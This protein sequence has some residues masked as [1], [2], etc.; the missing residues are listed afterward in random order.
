MTATTTSSPQQVTTTIGRLARA[1]RAAIPFAGRDATLPAIELVHLHCGGGTL[2][3][4]ATN[5]YILGHARIP[6]TGALGHPR[7]LH[8]SDAR[9]LRKDL[10]RRIAHRQD[11]AELVTLTEN[12]DHLTV[13]YGDTTITYTTP[14]GAG[15]APHLARILTALVTNDTV[16]VLQPIGLN[17]HVIKPVLKVA[18]LER[19]KPMRWLMTEPGQ[20]S[21]VEI[22]DWFVAAVMPAK[23]RG[24][25]GTISVDLPGSEAPSAEASR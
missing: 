9:A 2:T 17:A 8:R 20:P 13:G 19:Q 21:R 18:R 11:S 4:T 1:L 24:D 7:Y 10:N 23:L 14:P 15:Q 22:G 5:R 3:A 6:A 16:G 12:G 25:E